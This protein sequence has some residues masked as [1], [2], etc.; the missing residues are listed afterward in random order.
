ML[1]CNLNPN[2]LIKPC[3]D[4]ATASFGITALN[5]LNELYNGK[6]IYEDGEFPLEVMRYINDKIK[7]Y[8]EEDHHLYA[9][10]GTPAESLTGLQVKQ[11][12]KL[13]GVIKNVSDREYVSNSFHCHVT[14]EINP[15][16]KMTKEAR[17]WDL[18]G[19][20]RITYSR[21]PIDY[22]VEA[23]KSLIRHAMDLGL[24]YGTNLAK[25][26]CAQCGEE[27]LDD[28]NTENCPNC[29]S[30]QIVSINRMNGYLGYTRTIWQGSRMNDAKMSEIH[31]RKS[32]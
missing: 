32:M 13:Y 8:K 30:D 28:N 26:Y 12:R 1:W 22:N 5:E 17:F 15:I 2:E 29:G 20:G 11:F 19:G 3:L 27:F 18:F 16:D 23:Q 14:E 24:Y 10:Y 25:N 6:S 21:L 31:D 4:S 9:V 7:E